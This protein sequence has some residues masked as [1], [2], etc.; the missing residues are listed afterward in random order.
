MSW[1]TLRPQVK[2]VIDSVSG[3]QEVALSPKLKFSGYPAA[4]VL[5][6]DNDGDY[7][8]TKENIRTYAFIV[9]I[10]YDTKDSGIETAIASLEG[11]VDSVLDAF[12]QQDLKDSTTRIL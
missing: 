12:D 1:A 10:F 4:Y 7:E 5:P 6:S 2:D 11:I 3:F 8:T 9:R